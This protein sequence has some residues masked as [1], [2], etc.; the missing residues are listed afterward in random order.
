[1]LTDRW[2]SGILVCALTGAMAGCGSTSAAGGNGGGGGRGGRGGGGGPVPV[3]VGRVVQKDVPVDLA[4]IGNVE[5]Y[6]TIS[7]RSQITGALQEVRFSEGDFVKSGQLLFT[8]DPRPYQA[9]LDQAQATLERDKAML[10]QAQ[11]QL[12]K[13]IASDQYNAAESKRLASLHERGLVPRD[14][15]EQ[16]KASADASAALVNA[17]KASIEGAKATLIAQQASVETARLQL[18]YCQ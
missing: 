18:G 10:V 11:A 2:I 14:Q 13:D 6:S 5:A 3:V 17:D 4:A 1:M 16:G 7:V 9:A 8:V 15:S 12:E